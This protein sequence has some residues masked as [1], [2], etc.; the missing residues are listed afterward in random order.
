[1]SELLLIYMVLAV[2]AQPATGNAYPSYVPFANNYV[3]WKIIGFSGIGI[4]GTRFIFQWLYS[5]KHKEVRIPVIFWWQSLI[6]T[7]LCLAY[8][9]RQ[10]DSVGV[11]GYLFNIIPYTRNLMLIYAKKKRE[12][13]ELV[14]SSSHRDH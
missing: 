7:L 2:A 3:L 13:A 10:Q 11:A 1:M 6:G 4:F 12:Q 8:F 5:E 9:V 14:A